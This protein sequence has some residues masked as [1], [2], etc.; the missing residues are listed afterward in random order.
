MCEPPATYIF[1]W[2]PQK[3]NY[4]DGP[5]LFWTDKL[6]LGMANC[7]FFSSFS[8]YNFR[9]NQVWHLPRSSSNF[10][11]QI[12][13]S[14]LFFVLQLLGVQGLVLHDAPLWQANQLAI[15][16]CD[17]RRWGQI[18][19]LTDMSPFITLETG[20]LLFEEA[21]R[22]GVFKG[23]QTLGLKRW[24]AEARGFECNSLGYW[25]DTTLVHRTP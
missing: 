18:I 16:H 2:P 20:A 14:V 10:K 7:V 8:I 13:A 21:T 12:S 19:G 5:G 24:G 15:V 17:R 11:V 4:C 9:S 3:A 22:Q 6:T 1:A 23:L 25:C